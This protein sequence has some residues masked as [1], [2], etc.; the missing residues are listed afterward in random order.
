MISVIMEVEEDEEVAKDVRIWRAALAML[1]L[2]CGR[3]KRVKERVGKGGIR[4]KGA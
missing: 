4:V 3:E 2:I 1:H